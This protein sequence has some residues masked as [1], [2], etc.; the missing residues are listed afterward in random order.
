M[1]LI[2]QTAGLALFLVTMGVCRYSRI[3]SGIGRLS[4]AQVGIFSILYLSLILQLHDDETAIFTGILYT[5]LLMTTILMLS[6]LW[7]LTPDDLEQ[8]MR[9]ASVIFCL[10]GI[11]A[12]VI[13]GLPEGRNIGSIQPNLFA[14]PLFAGFIFSQFCAGITGIVVRILCL[15]MVILV[16]SRFALIGCISALILH[17][18]TFNS[19]STAKILALIVALVAGILFWPQIV[20]IMALDDSSRDL[21]FRLLGK[22]R[23][24]EPR[25]VGDQQSPVGYRLQTHDD[26]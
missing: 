10:F 25:A 13:L 5:F 22:R 4:L 2:G 16:S 21:I 19:L 18:L 3:I 9:V 12:I 23:I 1:V 26:P 14:A 24:L 11:S 17:Q 20:S 8:C 6:V 7:T 15:S